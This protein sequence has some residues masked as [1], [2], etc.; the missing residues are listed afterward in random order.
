MYAIQLKTKTDGF[1]ASGA[2]QIA[3]YQPQPNFCGRR[4]IESAIVRTIRQVATLT[5]FADHLQGVSSVNIL[6]ST[7]N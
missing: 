4:Q 7:L 2:Y 1:A 6:I 3:V 5:K